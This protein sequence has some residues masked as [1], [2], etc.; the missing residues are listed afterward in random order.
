MSFSP[1]HYRGSRS[2]GVAGC[3]HCNRVSSAGASNPILFTVRTRKRYRAIYDAH[4]QAA[5]GG[6]D[7]RPTADDVL[8]LPRAPEVG[9]ADAL[10][11]RSCGCRSAPATG[12]ELRRLV[13]ADLDDQ[14]LDVNLGAADVE[15]FDDRAQIVVDGLGSLDDQRI[16]RGVGLCTATPPRKAAEAPPRLPPDKG[17][18]PDTTLATAPATAA[19][20]GRGQRARA[21]RHDDAAARKAASAASAQPAP[22]PR[23]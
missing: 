15:F 2:V 7:P 12:F 14:R 13:G 5:A 16:V 17:A 1:P 21:L 6:G 9:A 3:S 20:G 23:S 11:V 19:A 22:P 10:H 8:P 4:V 18:A